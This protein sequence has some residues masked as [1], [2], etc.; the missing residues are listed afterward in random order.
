MSKFLFATTRD[1]LSSSLRSF[2]MNPKRT[3]MLWS[4]KNTT[5]SEGF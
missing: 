2:T 5:K 1:R 3:Q 4:K